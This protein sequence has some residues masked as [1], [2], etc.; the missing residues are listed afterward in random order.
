M[1]HDAP[2]VA[3]FDERAQALRLHDELQAADLATGALTL[4]T[5][6]DRRD[7]VD[8]LV[9]AG[10]GRSDAALFADEVCGGATL[11]VLRPAKAEHGR[12]AEIIDRHMPTRPGRP[13]VVTDQIPGDA[14]EPSTRRT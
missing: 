5:G 10:I 8:A 7:I 9:E 4:V 12:V 11:L 2:I 1:A 13:Q 14:S 3:L 6:S